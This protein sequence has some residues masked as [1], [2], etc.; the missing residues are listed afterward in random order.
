MAELKLESDEGL[1]LQSDGVKQLGRKGSLAGQLFLTN[2]HVIYVSKSFFGKTKAVDK[3][4]VRDIK[5]VQ[6]QAQ[7]FMLKSGSSG[8][9]QLVIH[10]RD[11][12]EAFEFESFPKRQIETWIGRIRSLLDGDPP[13]PFQNASAV[14]GSQFLGGLIRD[15]VDTVRQALGME[16]EKEAPAQRVAGKCQSCMAPLSGTKGKPVKCPYCNSE[17]YL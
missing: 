17:Q 15:T 13:G 7:V 4:P 11:R 2:R 12:E 1:L 6:D 3:Y 10:F 9:L 16:E 5:K 14:T 8:S